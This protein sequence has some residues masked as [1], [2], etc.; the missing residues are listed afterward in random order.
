VTI[1]IS[2]RR[3][4]SACHASQARSSWAVDEAGNPLRA[5]KARN[6]PLAGAEQANTRKVYGRILRRV[7]AEFGEDI[8]PDAASA[9]G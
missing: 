3:Y 6:R 9:W 5:Q 2:P 4:R 8:A 7:A 1:L